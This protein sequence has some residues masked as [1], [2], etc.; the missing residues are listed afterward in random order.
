M[1]RK[2]QNS[3]SNWSNVQP[4]HT[5]TQQNLPQQENPIFWSYTP[6]QRSP[7]QHIAQKR[8]QSSYQT[9]KPAEKC[10]CLCILWDQG[11]HLASSTQTCSGASGVPSTSIS[12][13]MSWKLYTH[14][15]MLGLPM[16]A[17]DF[18]QKKK[19]WGLL[20]R[21]QRSYVL[22]WLKLANRFQNACREKSCL[23]CVTAKGACETFIETQNGWPRP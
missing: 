2:I 23:V 17:I 19:A 10:T 18:F 22:A 11:V 5:M 14:S 21:Q 6:C 1:Y 20:E 7:G 3:S 8:E 12:G 9:H 4:G 15:M 13:M 16:S